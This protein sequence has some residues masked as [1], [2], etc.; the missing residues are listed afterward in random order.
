MPY[1]YDMDAFIVVASVSK[2]HMDPSIW[3]VLTAK[4][5]TPGAALADFAILKGRWDVA[6]GT[7]RPPVSTLRGIVRALSDLNLADDLW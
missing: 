5:K 6:T 3:T 2:D 1:K 7:F 4:S